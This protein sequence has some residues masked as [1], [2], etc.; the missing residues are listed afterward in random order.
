MWIS[1]GSDYGLPMTD[2]GAEACGAN[3]GG[4]ILYQASCIP[5]RATDATGSTDL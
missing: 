1:R 2:H 3:P 5:H 4:C